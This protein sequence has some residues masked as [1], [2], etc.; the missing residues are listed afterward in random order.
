MKVFRLFKLEQM[1]F[2]I[3]S[4]DKVGRCATCYLLAGPAVF[5]TPC[6]SSQTRVPI[7]GVDQGG[8]PDHTC[9]LV[10]TATPHNY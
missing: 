2:G 5:V 6:L 9:V 7:Q 3:Q 4:V 1:F 8:T 10:H